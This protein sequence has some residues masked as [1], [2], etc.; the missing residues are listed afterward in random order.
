MDES[1]SCR[2]HLSGINVFGVS[3]CPPGL[4]SLTA[5]VGDLWYQGLNSHR[6]VSGTGFELAADVPATPRLC[7]QYCTAQHVL[8]R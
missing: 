3:R 5:P 6:A 7:D 1:A 2:Q 4:A 8:P